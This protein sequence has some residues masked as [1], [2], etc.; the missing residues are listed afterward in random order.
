MRGRECFAIWRIFKVS[1]VSCF[2]ERLLKDTQK[3][4][5]LQIIFTGFNFLKQIDFL[6]KCVSERVSSKSNVFCSQSVAFL[7]KYRSQF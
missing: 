4:T 6:F 5:L 3:I 7:D 1:R 2:S